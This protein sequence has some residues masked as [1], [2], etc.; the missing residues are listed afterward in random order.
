MCA[1][2]AQPAHW[3]ILVE[4]GKFDAISGLAQPNDI[5]AEFSGR[6]SGELS[7]FYGALAFMESF[8][9]QL[10]KHAFAS[11]VQVN[12]M[13]WTAIPC[14]VTTEDEARLPSWTV[15]KPAR[16]SHPATTL[17]IRM[18]MNTQQRKHC[19]GSWLQKCFEGALPATRCNSICHGELP[20][21]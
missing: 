9:W 7:A 16:T 15:F 2:T 18:C 21:Q 5:S 14:Q 1:D 17:C 4:Y 20:S 10:D 8:C 19:Q 6:K 12:D 13:S 11:M 3:S